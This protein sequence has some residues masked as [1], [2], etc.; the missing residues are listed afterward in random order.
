MLDMIVSPVSLGLLF[1][2]FGVGMVGSLL[3]RKKDEIA[4]A[5]SNV[6]VVL[7]SIWG[8]LLALGVLIN[9]STISSQLQ[10]STF[11]QLSMNVQVDRLSAFFILIISLV[12]LFA[13]IYGM[14]YVK[15]YYKKY[16]IGAFG[17]FYNAFIFG[18][19]LVVTASNGLLFMFAWE[20]MSLAS[21]FLVIFDK[22]NRDSI[23]S[24]Y[25]YFIM[26]HIGAMFILFAIFLLYKYTGSFDFTVIKQQ[27]STIPQLVQYSVIGLTFVGL[28]VKAGIIPFHVWL[29]AAHPAA[30]SHVSGLMSG[31]MIKTAIYMMVRFYLDMFSPI[32]V[33][34]G[35]VVLIIG[36]ISA[37]LG[38]LYSLTEHDIKRLLAYSSI[39]NIGIILLAI[40]SALIF[41]A[42]GY[43][44][45]MLFALVAALLHSLN[46][47][48]FKSL[49]FFGS[50]S[51]IQSTHSRNI[52]KYGGLIKAM[53]L[54]AVLFL[55]GS[56][57]IAA[58]PPF[59]GF[60]SEWLTFQSLFGGVQIHSGYVV[61]VFVFGAGILA[62][63]SGLSLAAFVGAFGSTFLAR[64]RSENAKHAKES[65]GWM[66]AGMT[67]LAVLCLVAG[68]WSG[69]IV[70]KVKE[71]ASA[72]TSTDFSL[73]LPN[74][75]TNAI[76]DAAGRAT[77]SAPLILI[78]SMGTIAVIW[79]LVRYGVYGE[80]R[81]RIDKTWD[82]GTDL[83]G[84]MEI[85]D[86]S[87]AHSLIRIFKRVLRPTN[88]YNVV[89]EDKP[90]NKYA[91]PK[92]RTIL[93]DIKDVYYGYIYMPIYKAI[94]AFS[95]YIKAIQSGSVNLYV[96][97]M[98][99]ILIITLVVGV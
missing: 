29:P 14:G 30:P 5:W 97:Y 10:F 99:A 52:E 38:V 35:I 82:C 36:A 60:M 67:G 9:G 56:M 96:L 84:R 18:M 22:D 23:K 70:S 65:S 53:P 24:G 58:L 62:L 94:L 75:G 2:F 76:S 92:S 79:L 39:E 6:W 7:G 51:I 16:S 98:F 80:Q 44:D 34:F 20:I 49:L 77:V 73:S 59:N 66:I 11:T 32:P 72:V 28:G 54:T 13:S 83:N 41:S 86:S 87:F 4:N 17:F 95:Q 50:G 69:E 12:A 25:L 15:E 78:I 85:T 37:V 61:W 71:V 31:V 19:L 8:M 33:G 91:L 47:A 45:L 55:V 40:G 74:V 42:L 93:L 1:A 46:H 48:L 57:S 88:Q 26:T 90:I 81:V 68:V 64:P 63:V 27:F 43:H 21:Y 89:A 3:L